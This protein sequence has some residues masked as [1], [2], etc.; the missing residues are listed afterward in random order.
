MHAEG[1]MI[2]VRPRGILECLDLAVMFCG[3]RPLPVALAA[4]I[5]AVPCMLVNRL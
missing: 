3:R 4:V 1:L 2:T 5:G